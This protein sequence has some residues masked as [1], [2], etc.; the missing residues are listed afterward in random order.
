MVFYSLILD[1]HKGGCQA[2]L[3]GFKKAD[4]VSRHVEITLMGGT[5]AF[6][7]PKESIATVWTIKEDGSTSFFEAD[8]INNKIHFTIPTDVTSAPGEVFCEVRITAAEKLLT[9]PR[10]MLIVEDI[11]HDDEAAEAQNSFSALTSALERVLEAESGLGSKVDKTNGVEGN[12]AVF[13]KDGAIVDSSIAPARTYTMYYDESKDFDS[14]NI[15][16]A[17]AI[18]DD[19]EN[20]RPF[21]VYIDD[22][23]DIFPASVRHFSSSRL[24]VYAQNGNDIMKITY[25][26]ISS[27]VTYNTSTMISDSFSE[28]GDTAASQRA[29]AEW[30][31]AYVD[32]SITEG[33]W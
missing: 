16:V 21:S 22:F 23:S 25:N 12:I 8:V 26:S 9:A 10:F 1:T 2:T 13:G 29:T 7:I 30:V 33:A 6:E 31:K 18:R 17:I 24:I 32:E 20:G 14:D 15:K 4:L 3:E 11:L 27:T 5:Q 19:L 28:S